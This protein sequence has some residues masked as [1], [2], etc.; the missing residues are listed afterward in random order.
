MKKSDAGVGNKFLCGRN[1]TRKE[2]APFVGQPGFDQNIDKS[3]GGQRRIICRFNDYRTTRRN[4]GGHLMNDQIER[5]I[6][7]RHRD[8][9]P[10]RLARC[11]GH[12]AGPSGRQVHRDFGCH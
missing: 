1:V 7:S 6:K 3:S 12:A 5:V 2:S 11:E 9:R 4:C 8:N 10:D